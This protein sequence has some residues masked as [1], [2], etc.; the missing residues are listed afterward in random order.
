MTPFSRSASDLRTE[1]E[2]CLKGVTSAHRKH[3]LIFSLALQNKPPSVSL[4]LSRS[5]QAW[6]LIQNS[7]LFPF[8]K[9]LSPCPQINF[10]ILPLASLQSLIGLSVFSWS[11]TTV[12]VCVCFPAG[13]ELLY[14]PEVVRLYLSLLTESQNYNTLEAAAGALQNLSAGQWTVSPGLG[15]VNATSRHHDVMWIMELKSVVQIK[16]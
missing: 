5:Y 8:P 11:L 10:R 15:R 13:F 6:S 3:R 16:Q 2:H 4:L 14:Q 9:E 12:F 7:S 1:F